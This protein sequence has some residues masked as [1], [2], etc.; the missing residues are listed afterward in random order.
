MQKAIAKAKEQALSEEREKEKH[1]LNRWP[2]LSNT[3]SPGA[4]RL[5]TSDAGEFVKAAESHEK[6]KELTKLFKDHKEIEGKRFELDK[7]WA[8][9]QRFLR[10]VDN[11][12]LAANLPR[13]ADEKVLARYQRL[14]DAE[15]TS[16]RSPLDSH[17][18]ISEGTKTEA[19][20]AGS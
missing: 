19:K 5:L 11:I 4:L 3:L 8:W 13:L 17:S 10:A 6:F 18:V 7:K 12:A 14:L 20:K 16:L 2:N 1:L 15:S 9:H